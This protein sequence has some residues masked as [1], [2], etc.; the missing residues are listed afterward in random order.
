MKRL[1][2]RL[3]ALLALLALPNLAAAQD[4]AG[5]AVGD[6]LA[7]L[8]I[9]DLDGKDVNL[10]SIIGRKP[11]LIEF[12]ASW[13]TSCAAML[14]RLKAA[15]QEFGDDVTFVGI[16]VTVG[17]SR[18]KARQYVE[19]E[20]PPFQVLYDDAGTAAGAWDPPATSFIIIADRAGQVVY[21]G[22]GGTQNLTPALEAASGR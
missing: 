14:P 15:H 5:V 22:V 18:E 7:P 3:L 6:T 12:W 2:L 20:A 19:R 16:N 1:P 9:H 11:V 13:C 21:T 17:D 4:D 10:A 8:V